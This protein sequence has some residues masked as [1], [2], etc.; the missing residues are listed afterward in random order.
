[1]TQASDDLLS[2]LVAQA[3]TGAKNW[4]GYPQQRILNIKLCNEIAAAH[5][6][7]MTPKQVVDYVL[8]LNDMIFRRIVT[9]AGHSHRNEG[10]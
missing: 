5:A 10:S 3:Q 7:K 4:Y 2:Y 6:D 8:E 1:M 9:S